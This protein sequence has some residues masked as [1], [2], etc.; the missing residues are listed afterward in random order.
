MTGARTDDGMDQATFGLLRDTLRRF[1]DEPLIPAEETRGRRPGHFHR[2]V[3]LLRLYEGASRIQQ[4]TIA[5]E[6][7]RGAS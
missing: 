7:L 5:R 3:R 6:M 4:I 1:V 2:D